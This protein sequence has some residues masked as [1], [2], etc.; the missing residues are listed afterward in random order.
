MRE[1]ERDRT[2]LLLLRG[3][4]DCL[5]VGKVLAHSHSFSRPS[6]SILTTSASIFRPFFSFGIAAK[7]SRELIQ[8]LDHFDKHTTFLLYRK[9]SHLVVFHPRMYETQRTTKWKM[10]QKFKFIEN[11]FFQLFQRSLFFL[12]FD[13]W[14][15]PRRV[16]SK[17]V[18]KM[19]AL[20]KSHSF[21]SHFRQNHPRK[22]NTTK[23]K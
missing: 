2:H 12:L 5:W 16:W 1:C 8:S 14:Q 15:S 7:S 18:F 3:W 17:R 6:S 10:K 22:S 19:L 4:L 23:P 20:P 21:Q 9:R 11:I 13:L